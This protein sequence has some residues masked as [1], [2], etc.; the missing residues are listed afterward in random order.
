MQ[1]PPFPC[2]AMIGT[3]VRTPGPL[4]NSVWNSLPLVAIG[5]SPPQGGQDVPIGCGNAATTSGGRHALHFIECKSFSHWSCQV[6]RSGGL[7]SFAPGMTGGV[8]WSSNSI[9]PLPRSPISEMSSRMLRTAN[10]DGRVLPFSHLLIVGNVTPNLAA[11]FSW[12]RPRRHRVSRINVA[13]LASRGNSAPPWNNTRYY[14]VMKH[15]RN[16]HLPCRVVNWVSNH[17]GHFLLLRTLD[18]LSTSWLTLAHRAFML[19]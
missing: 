5:A 16:M 17:D 8:S 1:M 11:N 3:A 12:V 13:V 9:R 2:E 15:V 4:A 14:H 6:C 19:Y 7:A 18:F 10:G